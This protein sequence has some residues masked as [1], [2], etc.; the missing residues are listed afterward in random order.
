[1][2]YVRCNYAFFDYKTLNKVTTLTRTS[3]KKK[4]LFNNVIIMLDT[5]TS[6]KVPEN[7]H[8]NHVCA[9]SIA[10]RYK[11]ENICTLWGHKPSEC[12]ECINMILAALPGDKTIFYLHNMPYDYTFL[13]KFLFKEYGKPTR[14]L[15]VKPHYP[16]FFEFTNGLILKDSY[17]LSQKSLERWALD[18]NVEHRKA[19]G[20]WDYDKIR[21]QDYKFSKDELDYIE[22]DVLAGV[23]CLDITMQ[24]LHHYIYSLPYTSTGIVRGEARKIAKQHQAHER[25]ERMMP[26]YNVYMMLEQAFHGGYTHANRDVVNRVIDREV[27]CYD[28]TSS[29]PYVMLTEKYPMTKFSKFRNATVDE[30]IK[31]SDR[32]AF[33]TKLVLVK[34]RL[35]TDDIIMPVL[36]ASK[37]ERSINAVIDNGRI[38][39]AGLVEITITEQTLKLINEQYDSDIAL[40]T[41]VYYAR[42]EY[43]PRWFTDYIYKL[44]KEK[45]TLKGKDELNYGL[46]KAKLN[47]CYGMSVQHIIQNE[48]IE[49]YD[50]GD[51]E[52]VSK[53]TPEE[54]EKQIK[55]RN[56]FLNYS[57]GVWVTEYAMTNLHKLG[58]MCGTWLYSDTDSVYGTDWDEDA[59]KAYNEECVKKLEARDYGPVEFEGKKYCLG[60]ATLDGCYSQFKVLGAK[61]YCVRAEDGLHIT[62]AGVPK[63]GAIC[64]KDDIN[65]FT[66]GFVFDGKTTGKKQHTY[67]Y[68]DDIYIDDR[69]NETADSIDLS[70]CNYLLDDITIANWEE[71][72]REEIT[73]NVYDTS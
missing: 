67:I 34:P 36:Q 68:V 71:I 32:Y 43:L 60:V 59:V 11:H 46:S 65:N 44:F 22:N 72:F 27:K 38:L 64:L 15:N 69:G 62:V 55:N 10:I 51:Y 9:F 19:V 47:S 48:I 25:Y 49:N 8:P 17:I 53:Y 24:M 39:C 21:D 5:E 18:L 31:N 54:Y 3:K 42:K 20:K 33:V 63:K 16:I 35:K 58:A 41:D 52:T 14:Y 70:E 40:C 1:M 45:S 28:F 7:G 26:D 13:R 56:K 50:T 6:K 4:E 37:C 73:I 30:L 61:R 29:Y 2:S 66:R 57:W 12:I 23:E